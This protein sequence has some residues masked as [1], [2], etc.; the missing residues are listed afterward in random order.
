MTKPDFVAAER[1]AQAAF[2]GETVAPALVMEGSSYRLVAGGREHNLAPD[3]RDGV[4]AYFASNG[5]SGTPT[6]PTASR[7]RSAA[8][9]SWRRSPAGRSGWRASS[10]AVS[11][12]PSRR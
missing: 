10:T 3:I 2:F 8:S 4:S 9:I 1:T 11:A 5:S 7:P 6:R 12:W